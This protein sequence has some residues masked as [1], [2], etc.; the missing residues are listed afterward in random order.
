MAGELFLIIK[1]VQRSGDMLREARF[2]GSIAYLITSLRLAQG[3]SH[4]IPRSERR[5][6][7]SPQRDKCGA[8]GNGTHGAKLCRCD[9]AWVHESRRK[10]NLGKPEVR[11][12]HLATYKM[13]LKR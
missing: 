10:C 13:Q 1:D 12:R 6:A 9:V 2:G 7:T 11:A 4:N 8:P 5:R 3:H